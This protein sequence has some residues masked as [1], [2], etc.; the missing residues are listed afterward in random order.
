[1]FQIKG[2]QRDLSTHT[3]R[4]PGS[5]TGRKIAVNDIIGK[6]AKFDYGL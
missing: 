5:S 4:D 3:L 6:L 2:E 1:M